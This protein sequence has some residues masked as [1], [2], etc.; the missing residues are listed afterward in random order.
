MI[1]EELQNW[2]GFVI[3]QTKKIPLNKVKASKAETGA[4]VSSSQTLKID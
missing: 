3:E 4:L 1:Y 2:V